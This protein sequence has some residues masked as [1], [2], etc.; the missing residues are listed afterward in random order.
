MQWIRFQVLNLEQMYS[1]FN[2][3]VYTF[4]DTGKM[5]NYGKRTSGG[6]SSNSCHR[7]AIKVHTVASKFS[8]IQ[9]F[10]HFHYL[11]WEKQGVNQKCHVKCFD[12]YIFF[13]FFV[14]FYSL[15]NLRRRWEKI[16]FEGSVKYNIVSLS[17]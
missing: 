2:M 8:F 13:H 6:K 11:C 12:W 4:L 9:S 3:K 10:I 16:N 1:I 15:F 7:N 17:S 14:Q 5:K